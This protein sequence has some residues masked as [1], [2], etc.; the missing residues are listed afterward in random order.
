MGKQGTGGDDDL[1]LQEVRELA[2]RF[3]PDR[4]ESC[5]QQQLQEGTNVCEPE[6][7]SSDEEIIGILAKAQYVRDRMDEG[8][9]LTDAMRE[10]GRRIRVLQQGNAS[11]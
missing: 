9:P 6:P 4:L 3:D 2:R 11:D 10:L 7:G 5:I 8:A 1:H